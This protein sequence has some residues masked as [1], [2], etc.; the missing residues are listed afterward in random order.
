MNENETSKELFDDTI[1]LLKKLRDIYDAE[2]EK[3][4]EIKDKMPI[5][6]LL[7][8]EKFREDIMAEIADVS[9]HVRYLLGALRRVPIN[10][11]TP[12]KRDRLINDIR[13]NIF[14]IEYKVTRV[15]H[16]LKLSDDLVNGNTIDYI[17]SELLRRTDEF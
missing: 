11:R 2:D 17:I 6:K 1:K 16:Y 12:E 3:D 15:K 13:N 5:D 9:R 4:I 14:G 10:D 8:D 7:N